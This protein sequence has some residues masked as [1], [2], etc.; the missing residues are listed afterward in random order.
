MHHLHFWLMAILVITCGF[1]ISVIIG[2]FLGRI[3]K[4]MGE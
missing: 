3:I 4:T 2:S 1:L